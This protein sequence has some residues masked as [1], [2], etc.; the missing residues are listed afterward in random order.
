M[1]PRPYNLGLRKATIDETRARIIR[2]ARDLLG[3]PLAGTAFTVEAVARRADV[4]RMTV[5][6]Q[7]ESRHGL[8][9]AVY[10]DLAASGLVDRL[11]A[12]FNAADSPTAVAEVIRAFFAFWAADRL[13][14]RR[15]RALALLDPE[16]ERGVRAR[17]ERRR[18]ICRTVLS[19]VSPH[20]PP[21]ETGDAVDLLF[22]LSSF[23][24]Y[25]SLA[26]DGRTFEQ[27]AGLVIPLALAAAGLS[28]ST[29]S[30]T[31]L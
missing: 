12:V 17:D 18:A 13:V 4:A 23:E 10:D 8:L 25:D 11:P 21:Q 5:Y 16:I 28:S 2:A 1:S 7:F 20:R 26:S 30:D 6:Y 14:Q 31:S 24:T 29:S 3:D 15:A 22:T 9:E 19:R 27:C